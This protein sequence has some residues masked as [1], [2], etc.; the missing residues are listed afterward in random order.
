M[1]K[2]EPYAT[3][4]EYNKSVVRYRNTPVMKLAE[5]ARNHIVS[6]KRMTVS[7]VT[8]EPNIRITP[9]RHEPE[10]MVIVNDGACDFIVDGKLYH[11]EEGDVL[12]I[13]SNVEHGNYSSERGLRMIEVFSPP[14]QDMIAKLEQLKKGLKA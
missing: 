3:Q 4:E 6:S 12:I 2:K 14:R 5:G 10:Q 1:E 8:L 7:F 11:L 9:H 13:P